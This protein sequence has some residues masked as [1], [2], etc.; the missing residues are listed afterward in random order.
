MFVP[1]HDE[2]KRTGLSGAEVNAAIAYREQM[3]KNGARRR[4]KNANSASD[5]ARRSSRMRTKTASR[6]VKNT[7][8]RRSTRRRRMGTPTG[9]RSASDLSRRSQRS[10]RRHCRS[11]LW[12]RRRHLTRRSRLSLK[13][14]NGGSRC[15]PLLGHHAHAGRARGRGSMGRGTMK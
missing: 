12:R 13:A 6:I 8:S 9:R 10:G 5:R 1:A 2:G 14:R 3:L 15:G 11:T 7:T 4:K